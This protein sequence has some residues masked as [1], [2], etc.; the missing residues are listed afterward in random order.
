[1]FGSQFV[2]RIEIIVMPNFLHSAIAVLR[3]L[4]QQQ[5]QCQELVTSLLN[6]L[7]Y[8]QAFLARD[9]VMQLLFL[10]IELGLPSSSFLFKS[11]KYSTRL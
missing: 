2:S 5:L 7:S 9:E 11:F 8:D 4:D 3:V 10:V 6:H 1:M